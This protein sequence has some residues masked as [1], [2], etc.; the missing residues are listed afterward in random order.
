MSSPHDAPEADL[1]ALMGGVGDAVRAVGGTVL[2]GDLTAVPE[3]D[4]LH[5]RRRR[6]RRGRSRGAGCGP[7]DGLWLTGSVGGRARRSP[8]GSPAATPSPAARLAFARPAARLA[9]GQ[10]L[11]ANGALAMMDVS[12]GLGGDVPHLA[13][14]SGVAVDLVLESVPVHPAVA[15][16][17]ELAG[18]SRRVRGGGRGGLRTPGRAAAGVRCCGGRPGS[19]ARLACRSPA[20]AW[21][22]RGQGVQ[23]L[24]AGEPV[25]VRGFDHFR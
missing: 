15:D 2:G 4:R 24:R 10:W 14:A 11:A 8:P 17:A 18:T 20:S 22:A 1:V 5:H 16:E 23:F 6:G 19:G 7:G 12:D 3:V 21:R 9:A 13:A 25:V